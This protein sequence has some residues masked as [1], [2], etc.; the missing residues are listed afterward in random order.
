M[1]PAVETEE[2]DRALDG[3][4][5]SRLDK[6]G[7]VYDRW[8]KKNKHDAHSTWR[9]ISLIALNLSGELKYNLAE[10]VFNDIAKSVEEFKGI[11]YDSVGELGAK[12]NIKI[13]ETA[14]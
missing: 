12:L 7:T 6:F 9:I 10:D 13:K 11:D 5:M 3:M 14:A 4:S 8:A 2:L 1:R